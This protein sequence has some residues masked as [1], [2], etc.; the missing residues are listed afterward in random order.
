MIARAPQDNIHEVQIWRNLEKVHQEAISGAIV[1][2]KQSNEGEELLGVTSGNRG[3]ETNKSTSEAH[4]GWVD[5]PRMG[6]KH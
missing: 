1:P 6:I 5:K 4:L 3:L 2:N